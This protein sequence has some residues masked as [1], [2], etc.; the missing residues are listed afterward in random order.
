MKKIKLFADGLKINELDDDFGIDI[1]GYTFNPSI[2]KKHGVEDYIKHSKKLLPKCKNKPVSFE[3]F[4]D[5]EKEMIKQAKILNKLGNNIYVKVPITYTN[6]EFTSRVLET[7]VKENIKLNVTAIFTLDQIKK[8]LPIL[9]ETNTILSVFAGRI[10][11]CGLDACKIMKEICSEV[12]AN[13]KCETLW[14]SPRM[15][16]DYISAIN[17]G[18]EIITMQGQQIKKLKTFGKK[19]EDYSLETVKQFY[20]DALSSGFKI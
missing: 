13:S 4:A 6:K 11:D 19:P 3:V 5:E 20:N 15:P 18:A 16:Y 7:L 8:V 9:K 1:D 12:K 17:V 2:F 14:A 10:Y